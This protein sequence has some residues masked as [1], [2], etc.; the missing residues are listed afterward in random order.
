MTPRRAYNEKGKVNTLGLAIIT[1]TDASLLFMDVLKN[2]MLEPK[3]RQ[4]DYFVT[5]V[6]KIIRQTL[7]PMQIKTT[8]TESTVHWDTHIFITNWEAN[9]SIIVVCSLLQFETI[10]STDTGIRPIGFMH[11]RMNEPFVLMPQNHEVSLEA[12][13]QCLNSFRSQ[14][15]YTLQKRG[16]GR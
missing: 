10:E 15:P 11:N 8:D 16:T 7:P 6:C 2:T 9:I 3:I 12:K 13:S 4:Q 14:Y 1:S 5:E